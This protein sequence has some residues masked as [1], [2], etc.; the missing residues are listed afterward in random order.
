MHDY[1]CNN[2]PA[3]RFFVAT[4]CKLKLHKVTVLKTPEPGIAIRER[5]RGSDR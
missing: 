4:R 3:I 2:L 5:A 1:D